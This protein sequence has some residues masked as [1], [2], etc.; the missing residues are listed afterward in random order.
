M[1][2]LQV[3]LSS[4]WWLNVVSRALIRGMRIIIY[5]IVVFPFHVSNFGIVMWSLL[6]SFEQ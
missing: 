5:I 1:G 3:I 2:N 4:W 6:L